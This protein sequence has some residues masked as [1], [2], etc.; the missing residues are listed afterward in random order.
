MDLLHVTAASTDADI[1]LIQE[2][3]VSYLS[4]SAYVACKVQNTAIRKINPNIDLF[5]CQT[6]NG[7]VC[8]ETDMLSIYSCYVSPNIPHTE[9]EKYILDLATSVS[10]QKKPCIIGGDFNSKSTLWGSPTTDKRGQALTEWMAASSLVSVN[11]N[12]T[13]TFVRNDSE[14]HID[15]TLCSDKIANKIKNWKVM[16]EESLSLHR[17]ISFEIDLSEALASTVTPN[18]AKGWYVDPERLPHFIETFRKMTNTWKECVQGELKPESLT[19]IITE[20]CD[21]TFNR[22]SANLKRQKVYWWNDQIAEHRRNC[23][24]TRRKLKRLRVRN[25]ALAEETRR[26][27]A[28][29]R[30][31]LKQSIA[32]SKQAKWNELIEEV[33]KDPWGKA[34]KI[35]TG[36]TGCRPPTNLTQEE[37]VST[38]RELFPRDTIREKT[39]YNIEAEDIP[40]IQPAEIVVAAKKMKSKKAPGLDKLNPE[41]IKAV[42]SDS[43]KVVAEAFNTVL[44]SGEIPEIWKTAKLILIEKK[45]SGNAPKKYRP[46]CM[47][48]SLGK[49]FEAVIT[50]RLSAELE[51]KSPLSDNQ[52]GFRP[53]RATTDAIQTIQKKVD[54]NMNKFRGNRKYQLLITIDIKNAFNTASWTRI[55]QAL[56]EKSVSPYLLRMVDSYLENRYIAV[57]KNEEKLQCSRGVPQGSIMGPTLWNVLYDDVLKTPLPRDTT[58]IGYADDTAILVESKT[59]EDLKN[60]ANQALKQITDAIKAH[61]LEI[62][63]QKTEAILLYGGRK[64]KTVQVQ[65]ADATITSKEHLRYLGVTLGRNWNFGQH[66]RTATEKSIT[67][68]NTL[69]R[70]M[71][72]TRGPAEGRR[73]LL[74]SVVISI[75]LYAAVI[76]KSALKYEINR[77]TLQKSSR[78]ACLRVCRGYRT[79]S[80]DALNVICGTLPMDLLVETR[81]SPEKREECLSTWQERWSQSQKGSWTRTLIPRIEPW[82]CR[83]HGEL[84]FEITQFLSGHGKFGTYLKKFKIIESDECATCKVSDTP[85]HTFFECGK[86]TAERSSLVVSLGGAFGVNNAVKQMLESKAKWSLIEIYIRNVIKTKIAEEN[87]SR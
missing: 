6:G 51:E 5:N 54:E 14:S 49:L 35:V 48:N 15:I 45:T 71:P 44:S 79:I 43:P 3:T 11:S 36:K 84:T 87:Q 83:S 13:P 10:S 55:L 30:D 29:L 20:A 77:I 24:K 61:D 50:Y 64:L 76:W 23:N 81:C 82:I 63:A 52:Y 78:T 21:V 69:A 17:Y 26:E 28:G 67:V 16:L 57:G 7:F 74:R 58:A 66:I 47:L 19:R 65:V 42:A 75:T 46:L 41:L 38:A 22:K 9:F 34:Y 2:P 86:F 31:T 27:Y 40:P 59:A 56:Q 70:I 32:K 60:K 1:S 37:E 8:V 18:R 4:D 72:N 68:A 62:A 25:P 80:Y 53:R 85:E 12:R 39:N 73:R 33:D